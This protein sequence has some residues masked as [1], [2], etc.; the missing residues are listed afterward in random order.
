M[1]VIVTFFICFQYEQK[2]DFL[3][4]TVV[5]DRALVSDRCTD[6]FAP[7]Y[8]MPSSTTAVPTVSIYWGE[9]RHS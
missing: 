6:V 4:E 5:W 1:T 3:L 9:E 7:D 8:D 2:N